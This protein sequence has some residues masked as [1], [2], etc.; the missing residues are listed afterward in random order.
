MVCAFI[1][2]PFW[3]PALL[4]KQDGCWGW[5]YVILLCI[6]A[7]LFINYTNINPIHLK[8]GMCIYLV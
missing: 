4:K 2:V 1:K 6:G 8:Y 7:C 3:Y 5:F